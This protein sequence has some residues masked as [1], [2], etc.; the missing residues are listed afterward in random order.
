MKTKEEYKKAIKEIRKEK[1][2]SVV[3]SLMIMTISILLDCRKYLEKL[4]NKWE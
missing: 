2:S 3:I 4:N 1:H